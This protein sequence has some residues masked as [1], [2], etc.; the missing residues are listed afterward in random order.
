[1]SETRIV[2]LGCPIC[3]GDSFEQFYVEQPS[4][5]EGSG[6]SN[7]Y[8]YEVSKCKGCGWQDSPFK[9]ED[10]DEFLQRAFWIASLPKSRIMELRDKEPEK[11]YIELPY[12]SST[13]A[14]AESRVDGE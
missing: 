8:R 4:K 5:I 14:E 11:F 1:M 12:Q 6:F 10:A 3:K 7:A 13:P 9:H 2:K